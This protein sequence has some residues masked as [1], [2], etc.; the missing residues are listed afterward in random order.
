[1]KKQTPKI[2]SEEEFQ[3]LINAIPFVV[4]KRFIPYWE[5]F[6]YCASDA[7]MRMNESINL[8]PQDLVIKNNGRMQIVLKKQKNGTLNEILVPTSFLSQRLIDHCSI[9]EKEIEQSGGWLFFTPSKKDRRLSRIWGRIM[10]SKFRAVAGLEEVYKERRVT[11]KHAKGSLRRISY[12]TLR[13]FFGMRISAGENPQPIQN[14]Q[15]MMRHSNIQSTMRYLHQSTHLKEKI[16]DEVF[17]NPSKDLSD[18]KPIIKDVIKG[19]IEEMKTIK[20][21]S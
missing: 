14:V 1:M 7:G 8:T 21:F 10:F 9:Y 4:T 6:L 2:L 11:N 19:V 20:S 15:M 12:H 5:N 17:D 18:L 16:V 13:H 3:R